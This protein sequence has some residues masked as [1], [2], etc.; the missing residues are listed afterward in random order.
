MIKEYSDILSK[1]LHRHTKADIHQE[2]IDEIGYEILKEYFDYD[3]KSYK[4]KVDILKKDIEKYEKFDNTIR[5]YYFWCK[6]PILDLSIPVDFKLIVIFSVIE[7][8]MSGV[9]YTYFSEW[10]K[11]EIKINGLVI[12]TPEKVEVELNNYHNEHGSK[13]KVLKFFS[14]YFPEEDVDELLNSIKK[15]NSKE[16]KFVSL[17]SVDELFRFVDGARNLFVHKSTHI[18]FGSIK[19][20]ENDAEGYTHYDSN[21]LTSIGGISY[22]IDNSKLHIESIQKSFELA[23]FNFFFN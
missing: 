3:E 23:L 1:I 13:K 22:N 16:R 12:D 19:D 18:Q 14:D 7:T 9:K 2:V 17:N 20:Y 5:F 11:N 15:Y 10:I 21:T 4:T 8:L 6:R